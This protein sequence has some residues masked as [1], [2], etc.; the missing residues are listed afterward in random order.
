MKDT[1]RNSA[2]RLWDDYQNSVKYQN[3]TGLRTRLPRCVRFFEG[4]QWEKA[5]EDTKNFPR[6]VINVI[7]MIARNKIS[8]VLSAPVRIVYRADE[9]ELSPDAQGAASAE[10]FTRFSDYIQKEYGQSALDKRAVKDGAIKGSYVY[11]YYWDAQADGKGAATP[12]ALQCEVIDPVNVHFAN[13]TQQDEQK[14]E[15]IIISSRE[16]VDAVR[17]LV[18]D[19]EAKKRIGG[20]QYKENAYGEKEP[21]TNRLC[22]VLTRYF[23]R[24][25]EV[26]FERGTEGVLITPPTPLSPDIEAA[27]KA[28]G[29]ADDRGD[30]TPI[31]SDGGAMD[32]PGAAMPDG[33][34]SLDIT[35]VR[36]RARLYPVVVASWERREGSIYGI[37]EAE[38]A[39]SNQKVINNL[40]AMIVYNVQQTAWP[41]WLV[42]KG[43]LSEGETITNEPGEIIEDKTGTGRGIQQVPPA[44]MPSM[45]MELLDQIIGLV[46]N[47]SGASE[48]M[49]GETIGANMSGDAI[50]LLQSQAQQPIEALRDEFWEVKKKQG[51]VLAQFFKLFYHGRA[52]A[53]EEGEGAQKRMQMGI[54]EGDDYAGMDFDIV[55]ETM[56]STKYSVAGDINVLNSLFSSGNISLRTYIEA[57]PDDAMSNKSKILAGIDRDEQDKNAAMQQ[58]IESLTAQLQ[59]AADVIQKQREFADNAAA[60]IN[61]NK[62][63]KIALEE[64]Y[65]E[66]EAIR[67]EAVSKINAANAQIEAGNAKIREVSQ[68]ASEFAQVI[69]QAIE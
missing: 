13:P 16:N 49:T 57:Y 51:R 36:A 24:D 62:R 28:L 61:E 46:R 5:T 53:W 56:G 41:K 43:A 37:G 67:T 33:G 3:A 69:A 47:V 54:F 27:K 15:W 22:T 26:Y 40:L 50:A 58:Q 59:Q 35:P 4:D 17:A 34:E 8:S 32:E 48:V 30:D 45:P 12:G 20:S 55:V 21:D 38:R 60:I 66:T 63:L 19:P 7:A 10:L 9:V 64:Q 18:S 11:H 29:I 65:V 39:I 6:P 52:F 23:R 25:G 2:Q 42:I 44:A 31:A 14:Q 1:E 68:D